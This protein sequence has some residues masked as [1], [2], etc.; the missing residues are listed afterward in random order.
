MYWC[1]L[2]TIFLVSQAAS[3]APS[4][5][6][7]AIDWVFGVGHSNQGRCPMSCCQMVVLIQD[8][9]VLQVLASNHRLGLGVLG[10]K[11]HELRPIWGA[12]STSLDNQ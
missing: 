6:R 9:P 7:H 11:E 10:G 12:A 2:S 1:T 5:A 8:E 3:D 4:A